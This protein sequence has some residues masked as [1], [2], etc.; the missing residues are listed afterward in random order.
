LSDVASTAKCLN[1]RLL[2]AK[3]T[4]QL[5]M[6][7]FEVFDLFPKV[8]D[9]FALK[10][11]TGGLI[12]LLT[13]IFM[14]LVITV[15]FANREV[16]S[17]TQQAARFTGHEP[18]QSQIILNITI[19]YPCQLLRVRVHDNSGN[20]QLDSDQLITRQRLDKWLKPISD[21]LFDGDPNSLFSQCGSCHGSGYTMCCLTCFD[22]AAAFKLE[23]RLVPTLNGLEQCQR[24]WA[25]IAE[26][27][28]CHLSAEIGTRFRSGQVL[29]RA[30]GN[31]QMPVHYK[32]DLT[33][34]RNSVNLSHWIETLRWGPSF[35]GLINPLDNSQ[36]AQRGEGFY[37]FHYKLNLVPT[38]G[39]DDRGKP[40]HSH[41]YSAAF[42]EKAITKTVSKRFP[43]I[44]FEFDTAPIVV[45]YVSKSGSILKW[46]TGLLAIVGGGFTIGGLI[47]SFW[48]RINRKKE[49]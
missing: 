3:Q 20:H 13:F 11:Q 22:I 9:E 2:T 24:D 16:D 37:F 17:I 7:K 42:S 46:A 23:N 39:W 27:E 38:I 14:I 10:T 48:F 15:E 33:Y 31:I 45:K 49:H 25:A 5:L 44:A 30:G 34:Y 1:E 47:D 36:Y 18:E 6:R 35:K 21:P 41:Q 19:A 40:V 12:S 32:H 8:N 26:G 43:A 28:S 4:L 29:I